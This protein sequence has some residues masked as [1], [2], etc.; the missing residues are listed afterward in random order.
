MST[1]PFPPFG[2]APQ[3]FAAWPPGVSN[4]FAG[5]A[6]APADPMAMAMG[7][8]GQMQQVAAGFGA[9]QPSPAEFAG[10]WRAALGNTGLPGAYMLGGARRWLEL[11]AF[12]FAREHQERWQHLGK[13]MVELQAAAQAFQGI[14]AEVGQDATRRFESLLE[15]RDAE[16]VESARAVFD[17]WVD[18][19]EDA[20]ADAALG[21]RFQAAFGDYVNAQMR[22]RAAMQREAEQVCAQWGMPQR[23]EVDGAHRKVADLERRVRELEARLQPAA[24]A[25][26]PAVATAPRRG[27]RKATGD[28]P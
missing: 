24:P 3:S 7:W 12:G 21:E 5:M 22:V 15:R 14:L 17:L 25:A 18:A 16:P 13:A 27:K 23:S 1:A 6:A 8:L 9:S 20:Y 10:A 4:A 28:A 2:F 26:P 19:A 11:P